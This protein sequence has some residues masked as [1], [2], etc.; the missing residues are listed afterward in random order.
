[1]RRTVFTDRDFQMAAD[2]YLVDN[3][4]WQAEIQRRVVESKVWAPPSF[5]AL[6]AP[7]VEGVGVGL[8]EEPILLQDPMALHQEALE[9]ADREAQELKEKILGEAREAAGREAEEIRVAAQGAAELVRTRAE[10]EA[11]GAAEAIRKQAE[12]DGKA[13]GL[14]VGRVEGLAAGQVEGKAQYE[15]LIREW[16]GLLSSTL[17]ER[18][19][20]L[21][22]MEPLLVDLVGD[23]LLK[24]LR[25][26]ALERPEL[27]VELVGQSIRMAHDKVRLRIHLHPAD[28][29]RVGRVRHELQ[30]SVGAGELELVPDGRIEQGGCLLETEAGSVDAR[31]GTLVS[32][33]QDA[34]RTGV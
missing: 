10:E 30:L 26:E 18:R 8:G 23:A 7:P 32:Q 13:E 20:A 22:D 34:I 11:K 2:G 31:L 27:V 29:E 9:R 5:E 28:V 12:Q 25:R 1:M 15:G 21:A 4:P 24:C 14:S 16:D 33:A 6:E 17:S 19:K 3:E